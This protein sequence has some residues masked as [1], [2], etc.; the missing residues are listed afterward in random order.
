MI[1]FDTKKDMEYFNNLYYKM[2]EKDKEIERL[3]A[4]STE[5][6]SK[7]YKYQDRIDKAIKYIEEETRYSNLLGTV[8]FYGDT[9][10]LINLLKGDNNV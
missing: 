1:R 5:W 9:D 6:E 4:E 10:Y 8:E 3:T 7:C 2:C